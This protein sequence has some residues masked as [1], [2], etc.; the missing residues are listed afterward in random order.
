M[1]HLLFA[2]AAAT[3]L[4]CFVD[5]SEAQEHNCAA[6][7]ATHMSPSSFVGASA[8]VLTGAESEADIALPPRPAG[9]RR[10]ARRLAVSAVGTPEH[11][12]VADCRMLP[13]RRDL[14]S[15][16]Q[17]VLQM[18]ELYW[19][20][21]ISMHSPSEGRAYLGLPPYARGPQLDHDASVMTH[22]GE[23]NADSTAL[24]TW[25]HEYAEVRRLA[26]IRAQV[27]ERERMSELK[28]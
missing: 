13:P 5:A 4:T 18:P 2:L 11:E 23:D 20:D 15:H 24:S 3:S 10:H 9:H 6:G 7:R 26:Y 22:N 14:P 27:V 1:K 19:A 28:K 25:G 12:F 8:E 21:R 17:S 16:T